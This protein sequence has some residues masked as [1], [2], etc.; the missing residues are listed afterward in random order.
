MLSMQYIQE[1]IRLDRDNTERMFTVPDG[2]EEDVW[3]YEHLR[4]AF[5]PPLLHFSTPTNHLTM[6]AYYSLTGNIFI[7]EDS[8][9][10]VEFTLDGKFR[11]TKI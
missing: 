4:H 6:L 11:V 10:S 1:L 8:A 2:Q 5:T 3:K 9:Y 7:M